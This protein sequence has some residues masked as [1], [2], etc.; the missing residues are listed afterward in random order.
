MLSLEGIGDC[1][2]MR[3]GLR[4]PMTYFRAKTGDC[5]PFSRKGHGL[6]LWNSVKLPDHPGP[7]MVGRLFGTG[8][9]RSAM[10]WFRTG[11]SNIRFFFGF[12]W[13]NI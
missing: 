6:F 7:G 1:F 3:K 9:E 5:L 4:L 12:G 2:T 13:F 8:Q 10:P 11:M